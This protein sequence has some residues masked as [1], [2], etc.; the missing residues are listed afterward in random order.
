MA[1][2]KS[3]TAI[4]AVLGHGLEARGTKFVAAHEESAGIVVQHGGAVTRRFCLC[5]RCL[6]KFLTERTEW[7]CE[8]CEKLF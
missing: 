3:A 7:L 6:K 5:P 1:A 4:L 8:F 2:T